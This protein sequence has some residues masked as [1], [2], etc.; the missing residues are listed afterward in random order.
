M[1][2]DEFGDFEGKIDLHLHTCFSDGKST[3]EAVCEQFKN[4]KYISITDHNT[5]GA[6]LKTD[7]LKHKNLIR[8]IEFDC[9]YKGVLIHILGYGIDVCNEQIQALCAKTKGETQWDIIRLFKAKNPQKVID[10]IHSA[11]GVAVLAHPACCWCFSLDKLVHGLIRLNLDGL[12]VFYP[13][14]RHRGIIKFHNVSN[15]LK[16]A[17]KYNLLKTG[18][19]DFHD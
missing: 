16:V 10:A 2:K 15:V 4:F 19:S 18:G 17:D 12:E 14:K 6:Y 1:N 5:L 9:W 3:P 8:G 13:Y 11:G 7:I